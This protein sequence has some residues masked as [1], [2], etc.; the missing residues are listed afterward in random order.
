MNEVIQGTVR[1][2]EPRYKSRSDN[3]IIDEIRI[4]YH[5]GE[6]LFYL[7]FGRYAE[8]LNA[9]FRQQAVPSVEFDDFMLEL[10]IRLFMNRCAAII[11]YDERKA[12][13]KTYLSRIAHNVLYDMNAK[14]MPLLDASCIRDSVANVD[15]VEFYMLVDAINSYPNKDGR[16][17]LIKTIEGYKSKEIA[18]MLTSRR[19]EEG[20]LE[21]DK[22][23]KPSYI[24]TLRSRTLKAL[25][26]R[27][28]APD[29]ASPSPCMAE[30]SEACSENVMDMEV[31][32][33]APARFARPDYGFNNMF[34]SNLC[35]LYNIIMVR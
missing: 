34:I 3:E 1:E 17:V 5:A 23:L 8:M 11:A 12:S 22:E 4:G 2:L 19:H 31:K 29:L 10:D 6:A 20:T 30:P 26:S 7:L 28:A 13:F 27:L 18:V 32:V 15:D 21:E 33:M 24:D 16:Y 9:L 35:D 25:R 14:E